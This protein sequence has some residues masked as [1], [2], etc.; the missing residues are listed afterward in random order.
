MATRKKKADKPLLW[1]PDY[2]TPLITPTGIAIGCAYEP[3]A[4]FDLTEEELWIQNLLLPQ[5]V[6]VL[7]RFNMSDRLMFYA[8]LAAAVAAVYLL[9]RH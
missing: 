6:A 3:P 4:R 2:R 7:P 5:G 8:G 9:L 1:N